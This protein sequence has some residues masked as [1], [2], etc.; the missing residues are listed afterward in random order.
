[1]TA[2]AVARPQSQELSE[3]T[4]IVCKPRLPS[5]SHL[6]TSVSSLTFD[7][8]LA[9]P[10]ISPDG[11][12]VSSV[13]GVS[14]TA[15]SCRA[16][17]G[18]YSPRRSPTKYG[19]S[20]SLNMDTEQGLR[21]CGACAYP[22]A[23]RRGLLPSGG[24]QRRRNSLPAGIA[25]TSN[26]PGRS[27]S[28]AHSSICTPSPPPTRCS[29]APMAR[30]ADRN[31]AR[32]LRNSPDASACQRRASTKSDASSADASFTSNVLGS[33]CVFRHSTP[34][35]AEL[36]TASTTLPMATEPTQQH[37]RTHSPPTLAL[38]QAAPL[39]CDGRPVEL[40]DFKTERS[41]I[42]SAIRRST[43]DVS[44]ACDFCTVRADMLLLQPRVS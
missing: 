8:E 15:A 4:P 36:T 25:S 10:G 34:P 24:S 35:A 5:K 22:H 41:T 31:S 29:T 6:T 20:E 17:G 7:D 18:N 44:V 12:L 3:A 11:R 14:P 2:A 9:P 40:L 23:R 27:P 21:A 43:V 1:M 26:L 16:V 19:R 33:A 42:L 38:L 39:V 32:S 13:Q 28:P 37:A 30:P